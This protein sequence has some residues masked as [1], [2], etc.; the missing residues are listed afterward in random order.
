M[1]LLKI[2]ISVSVCPCVHCVQRFT[3]RSGGG[4]GSPEAGIEGNC[5]SSGISLENLTQVFP[6]EQQLPLMAEPSLLLHFENFI[7]AESYQVKSPLL[8]IT[9]EIIPWYIIPFKM[10]TVRKQILACMPRPHPMHNTYSLLF[11][12]NQLPVPRAWQ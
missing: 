5:E 2:F 8:N 7:Q 3:K 9:L 1:G 11:P 10:R 6:D 12:S 4:T